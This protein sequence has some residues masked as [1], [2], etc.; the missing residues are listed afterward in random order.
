MTIRK[1][2]KFRLF[3]LKRR[4]HFLLTCLH[5]NSKVAEKQT[6][7]INRTTKVGINNVF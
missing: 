1:K 2:R 7:Q 3:N 4:H 6:T 5:L